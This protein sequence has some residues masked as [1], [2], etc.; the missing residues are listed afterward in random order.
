V[1]TTIDRWFD[2]PYQHY[3]PAVLEMRGDIRQEW[4]VYTEVAARLGITIKMAGGDI[5]PGMEITA[6]DVLDLI[7]ANS[8]LPLAELR[9]HV[10]GALFPEYVT[11]VQP[12]EEGANARLEMVPEGI[13]EE[14]AEVF[15]ESTSASVIKGFDPAVHTFRMSTRRLK[16]VFNS[17]GREVEKLRER[18]GTN[19]AHLNSADLAELGVK[20]G[21]IVEVASPKGAIKAVVKAADD[22]SRGT[23][24]M[25]HAWGGLPDTPSD[26]GIVGS[27]TGALIDL[28]SGYDA[29]TGIPV[30]SAIPVAIRPAPVG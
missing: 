30:M 3:T 17:S 12:A 19:F 22:V 11:T 8:K 15:A 18:E 23:V 6:D 2:Q 14:M 4:Q 27:T 9:K 1:P 16:S 20:D 21:D 26:L 24:S 10:G 5:T 7:Y 28:E 25:A 13:A 29:I